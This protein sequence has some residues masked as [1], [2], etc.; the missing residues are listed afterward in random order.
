MKVVLS[1]LVVAIVSL[2]SLAKENGESKFEQNLYYRALIAAL[3]ARAQDPSVPTP[4]TLSSVSSAEIECYN[5]R[6]A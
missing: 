1:L 2:S 3:A 5:Q 4:M 6:A